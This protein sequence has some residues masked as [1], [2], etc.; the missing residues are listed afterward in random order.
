MSHSAWEENFYRNS[1]KQL[2][3]NSYIR[4]ILYLRCF[5]HL[6]GRLAPNFRNCSLRNIVLTGQVSIVLLVRSFLSRSSRK[7]LQ[8]LNVLRRGF[9]PSFLLIIRLTQR[10]FTNEQADF[11]KINEKSQIS[12]FSRHNFHNFQSMKWE[13]A[14]DQISFEFIQNFQKFQIFQD[15]K[16]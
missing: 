13:T 16:R 3:R 15:L 7:N 9:V 14:S 12:V 10:W 2:L 11:T 5:P 1:V 8:K 4:K 6:M